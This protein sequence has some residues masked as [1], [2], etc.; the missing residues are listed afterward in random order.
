M[1][2]GGASRS[3]LQEH[4]QLSFLPFALAFPPPKPVLFQFMLLPERFYLHC[5]FAQVL[6]WAEDVCAVA[7][8]TRRNTSQHRHDQVPLHRPLLQRRYIVHFFT[9]PALPLG[10]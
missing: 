7:A 4:F 3:M 1:F 8:A 6:R 9:P 2:L 5:R 10:C